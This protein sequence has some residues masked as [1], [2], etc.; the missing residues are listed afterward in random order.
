MTGP[1]RAPFSASARLRRA[2]SQTGQISRSPITAGQKSRAPSAGS[3]K[4]KAAIRTLE[5]LL[6]GTAADLTVIGAHKA[7]ENYLTYQA[8]GDDD[9]IDVACSMVVISDG[10]QSGQT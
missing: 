2:A 6:R 7:I 5:A 9:A 10:R 8:F 3:G 4:S 1:Y